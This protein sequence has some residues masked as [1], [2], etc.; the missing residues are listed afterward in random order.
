MGLPTIAAYVLLAIIVAPALESAGIPL[1]AAH[2]FVLYFGTLSVLTPPVCLASY[3]ASTIS[4]ANPMSTG[5]LG[6]RLSLV[7]FLLPFVFVYNPSF[8]L[9][10]PSVQMI[11]PLATFILSV[12]ALATAL[13]GFFIAKLNV[14]QRA[15][16]LVAAVALITR[17]YWTDLAGLIIL[18]IVYTPQAVAFI[19]SKKTGTVES[20][21]K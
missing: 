11:I 5:F 3:T 19:K 12:L 6:F 9:I 8:V 15:I 20:S 18:A 21:H 7:G 1:M 2:L 14:F 16:L 17:N 4:G 10:A 13:Q